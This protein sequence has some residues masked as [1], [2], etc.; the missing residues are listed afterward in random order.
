MCLVMF[1]LYKA[2]DHP[3]GN[4]GSYTHSVIYRPDEYNGDEEKHSVRVSYYLYT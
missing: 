2:V 3:R 1:F 4:F